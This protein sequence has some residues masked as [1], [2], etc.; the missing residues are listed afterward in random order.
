[1]LGNEIQVMSLAEIDCHDNIP[2]TAD[3]LEGNA[4]IKARWVKERYGLDCFADD[5]GLEVAALN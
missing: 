5:T 1:M 3:T 2:E 4:L